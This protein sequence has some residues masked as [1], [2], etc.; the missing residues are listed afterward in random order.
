MAISQIAIPQGAMLH[1][2]ST[3][4]AAGIG[5]DDER[6]GCAPCGLTRS[7][8]SMG[9]REDSLPHPPGDCRPGTQSRGTNGT[10]LPPGAVAFSAVLLCVVTTLCRAAL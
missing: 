6:R 2:A 9:R 8:D 5:A 4:I 10:R 3:R 7:G 1:I